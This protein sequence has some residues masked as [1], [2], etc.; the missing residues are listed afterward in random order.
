[1]S[2]SD[3]ISFDESLLDNLCMVA[4]NS[5]KENAADIL[6]QLEMIRSQQIDYFDLRIDQLKRQKKQVEEYYEF[7]E[8]RVEE[9]SEDLTQVPFS[10]IFDPQGSIKSSI[11]F[12][13]SNWKN[14]YLDP[15]QVYSDF[16]KIMLS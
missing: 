16:K 1:M 7:A 2:S 14:L 12:S 4:L 6:R 15:N 8:R 11:L 9:I 13:S 5:E 10:E 3:I